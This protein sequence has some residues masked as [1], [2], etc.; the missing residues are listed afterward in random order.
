MKINLGSKPTGQTMLDT[1]LDA[2]TLGD[3]SAHRPGN[4]GQH[5]PRDKARQRDPI[6]STGRSDQHSRHQRCGGVWLC[7]RPS[8]VL[9]TADLPV[10]E[11]DEWKKR[12][13][14]WQLFSCSGV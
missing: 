6:V 14:Q 4:L 12:C 2:A 13:P 1:Y 9:V 7:H 11:L 5:N 10:T 3:G 8:S